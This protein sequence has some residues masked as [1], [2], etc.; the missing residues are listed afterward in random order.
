[1]NLNQLYKKCTAI[2]EQN[3]IENAAYESQRLIEKVFGFD[4]V[5]MIAFG[6]HEADPEKELL[7]SQFVKRRLNR[8]PLQYILG[9][10]SFMGFEFKVGEGVLIPRDDTEVVVCLCLDFLKDRQCKK[11][12]DLCSGSGAIAVALNKIEKANVTAI[13]LSNNALNYLNKNIALNQ[14]SVKAMKGDIFECYTAFPDSE[15]DLIVSNP[16]YIITSEIPQLQPEVQKEP[17]MALDGGADGYDFYK[18][19]ITHWSKKLKYGGALAFELGEGQADSIKT[20]MADNGFG[21]FKISSDF[22]DIQRAIIGTL[23]HK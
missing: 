6:N 1:M 15:F 21:N 9:E 20:L 23:I 2:L 4:R 19:I 12:I 16:P 18:C 22:G 7:I 3:N 10:W 11:V 8:E 17:V 5:H 13:E 14:S